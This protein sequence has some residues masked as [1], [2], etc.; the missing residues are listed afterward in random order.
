MLLSSKSMVKQKTVLTISPLHI[1]YLIFLSIYTHIY[2]YVF[3]CVHAYK[4]K[5]YSL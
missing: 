5:I 3:V 4:G 1:N 2:T